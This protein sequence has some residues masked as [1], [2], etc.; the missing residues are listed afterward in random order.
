MPGKI[1]KMKSKISVIVVFA[2]ILSIFNFSFAA[3]TPESPRPLVLVVPITLTIDGKDSPSD[4]EVVAAVA[5]LMAE[6]GK[7]DTLIFN[8]DLPTITR[9]VFEGK[10]KSESLKKISDASAA[11]EIGRALNVGYTLVC[12]GTVIGNQVDVALELLKVPSGGRWIAASGSLIAEG[13]GSIADINRKNAIMTAASSAVSQ[14]AIMAFG[15]AVTQPTEERTEYVPAPAVP[16][17]SEAK[18]RNIQAEYAQHIKQADEYIQKND[19]A[20]GIHELREAINLDPANSE[21]R[22]KLAE[23]YWKL[24]MFEEAIDECRRGLLFDKSNA[25]L[26]TTLVQYYIAMGDLEEAAADC[27]KILQLEPQNVKVRISLGDIY[28]NQGKVDEAAKSYE[29]ATKLDPKDPLPHEK[30]YK[31]YAAKRMHS[32]ALEHLFRAKEVAQNGELTDTER[33]KI[34]ARILEERFNVLIEKLK[35]ASEDYSRQKLSRED[36][37]Q[38]CKD[39]D[40]EAEGLATFI[41]GQKSP[42]NLKDVHSRAVFAVSLLAQATSNLVLY[43]ETERKQYLDQA[44]VLQDEAKAEIAAFVGAVS[45][46]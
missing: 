31:L 1:N 41:S 43:L 17:I 22:V 38:E 29:E 16:K 11:L 10:L 39:A 44:S 14:I 37:Y 26:L 25:S 24:G 7:V 2:L 27:Q 23:L 3:R 42:D 33:Y 12:R 20:N 46:V 15:G 19:V 34:L 8:P 18:P 30:L 21:S 9:A 13:M 36:Y 35:I 4:P 6:G 28:W 5:K 32:Q 45:K 40:A